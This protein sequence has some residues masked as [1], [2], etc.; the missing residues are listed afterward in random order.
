MPKT[1]TI[2]KFK[3]RPTN[4]N[5]SNMVNRY[6]TPSKQLAWH[7]AKFHRTTTPSDFAGWYNP[8]SWVNI[9]HEAVPRFEMPTSINGLEF[10]P[11]ELQ[12][13]SL[14][15]RMGAGGVLYKTKKTPQTLVNI[16]G[17][18]NKQGQYDYWAHK[19]NQYIDIGGLNITD[20]WSYGT[21]PSKLW[22]YVVTEIPNGLVY[23]PLAKYIAT[24]HDP[25]GS[26]FTKEY[27]KAAPSTSRIKQRIVDSGLHLFLLDFVFQRKLNPAMLTPGMLGVLINSDTGKV[28]KMTLAPVCP[29]FTAVPE[30][31]TENDLKKMHI[32]SFTSI[33]YSIISGKSAATEWHSHEVESIIDKLV[34]WILAG[35]LGHMTIEWFRTIKGL[36]GLSGIVGGM[37]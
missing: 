24:P 37:L 10:L 25:K 3:A 26:S 2:R 22:G 5:V 35:M 36:V 8:K 15:T 20:V 4:R 18:I 33:C 30:D 1:P 13:L 23:W 34:P 29:V 11:K 19:V 21:M 7:N 16:S 17:I 27:N 31:F 12:N 32:L 9:R 14:V 6:F 28:E